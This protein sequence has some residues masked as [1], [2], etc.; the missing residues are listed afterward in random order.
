MDGLVA[1]RELRGARNGRNMLIFACAVLILVVAFQAA[2][3]RDQKSVVVLVPSQFPDGTVA[4]GGQVS[5]GYLEGLARDA[6][7]SLLNVTPETTNYARDNLA[8]LAAP[9]A[10]IEVIALWDDIMEEVRR[11]EIATAFYPTG[12]ET[13]ASGLMVLVDGELSTYLGTSLVRKERKRYE[14][15]FVSVNSSV[16]ISKISELE[17]PA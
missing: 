15:R 9:H 4:H 10:R 12:L 13:S 1:M 17:I 2:A 3:L 14:V 5:P 7:Y 16:R 11:R 8:R 6:V